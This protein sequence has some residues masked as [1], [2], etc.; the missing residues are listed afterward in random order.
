M[1]QDQRLEEGLE[2]LYILRERGT[3]ERSNFLRECREAQPEELLE[4]LRREHLVQQEGAELHLTAVGLQRAEGIIRRHRLAEVLMH[5]VLQ[6]GDREM[7]E[8]ACAMEHM[9]SEDAVDRVCAFLGHPTH[10][11]HGGPIPPGRCCRLTTE[12]GERVQPL[13]EMNVGDL[14]EVIHIRPRHHARLDRLGAYGLVPRSVVRLHQK[15]PSFVIQIDETDLALD[16]DI[17]GDIYV[18]KAPEESN[19]NR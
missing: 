4:Q 2:L 5:S 7:E 16:I 17:A 6:I 15:K 9:L 14:C 13:S 1:S 8:T 11:P 12:E 18:R 10:C 19:R 3:P